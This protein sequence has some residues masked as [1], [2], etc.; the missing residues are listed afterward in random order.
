MN[1]EQS[2]VEFDLKDILP[3]GLGLVLAGIAIAYGIQVTGDIRDDTCTTDGG[4]SNGER[5]WTD[6]NY[7][8]ST[9]SA[10]FNATRDTVTGVAKFPE[11]FTLIATVVVAAI[12]LGIVLRYLAGFTSR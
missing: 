10:Q 1:P 6:T 12:I 8:V 4:F 11:K 3:L 7:N 5:C 9:E 2:I